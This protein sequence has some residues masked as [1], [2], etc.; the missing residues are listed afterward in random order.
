MFATLLF[1][2]ALGPGAAVSR[3][4]LLLPPPHRA[5]FGVTDTGVE[6]D[7]TSFADSV[8]RHPAVIETFQRWRGPLHGSLARWQNAGARPMVHITT[9]ASDG[10]TETITPRSIALGNG[11]D[12]LYR[13]N[14]L[15]WGHH[16]PAYLRPLGEPNRC[17]NVYAAY[18]CSGAPRP[19]HSPYW[20]RQAFRRIYIVVRGGGKLAKINQR[21]AVAGLPELRSRGTLPAGL[22]AAPVA[23]VWSP[24][25]TGS[26]ANRRNAAKRFYPGAAYVDWVGTD[27]YSGYADWTSLSRFYRRYRGKPFAFTEWGVEGSD[28]PTFVRRL[29]TFVRRH[30]R[31]R[32]IVYYQDFG[33]T[34]PYRLQNYPGSLAAA[35]RLLA[36]PGYVAVAPH[37]PRPPPPPEGGVSQ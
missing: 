27:F 31:C 22:P 18:D 29:F 8:G 2:L 30:D 23:V 4:L 34:S 10:V 9:A 24:L 13:L 17:L 12:Y 20:Y 37:A 11:D 1:V 6:S 32:M 33:A 36:S 14:R 3:G 19:G 35:R 15:F 28:D 16:L 5:F 21:L 7:F 25:T 26:P